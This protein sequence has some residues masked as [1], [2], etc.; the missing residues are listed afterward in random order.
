M[1]TITATP[2]QISQA[3]KVVAASTK[4][5]SSNFYYA[6]ITLPPDKRKAVYAGYSF[7]RMADDIVDNGELGGQAGEALESLS[8]AV[9]RFLRPERR[10]GAGQVNPLPNLALPLPRPGLRAG[11]GQHLR[12]RR[13]RA[14]LGHQQNALAP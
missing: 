4:A 6:F 2:E 1:P 3:Y 10:F 9:R 11:L 12:A 5:A 8:G 7:C 13:H 14:V